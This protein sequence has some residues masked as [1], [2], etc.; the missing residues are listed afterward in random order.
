M[1]QKM[2]SDLPDFVGRE[3]EGQAALRRLCFRAPEEVEK[4][5]LWR[6]ARTERLPQWT[7]EGIRQGSI[8]MEGFFDFRRLR[9]ASYHWIKNKT[10]V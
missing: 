5:Y 10:W 4:T 3:K 6:Q 9:V 8:G 2:D 7:G 1:V